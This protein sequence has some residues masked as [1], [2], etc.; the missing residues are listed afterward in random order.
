MLKIW[1]RVTIVVGALMGTIPFFHVWEMYSVNSSKGQSLSGALFFVFGVMTWLIY[2]VLKKDRIITACNGIAV[3][4]GSIY[5]V[6]IIY[7][8]E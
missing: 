1:S 7:F 6:A 8:A 2:G 3:V 4:A 5:V